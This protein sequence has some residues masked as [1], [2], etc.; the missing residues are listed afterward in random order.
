MY[1]AMAVSKINT[2]EIWIMYEKN[3]LKVFFFPSHNAGI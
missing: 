3:Y 2:F 1:V